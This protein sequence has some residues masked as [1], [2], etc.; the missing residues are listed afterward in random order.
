MKLPTSDFS[1]DEQ[2]NYTKLWWNSKVYFTININIQCSK[3]I[4]NIMFNQ[5]L[6]TGLSM[7]SSYII[8]KYLGFIH[9]YYSKIKGKLKR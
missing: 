7:I 1:K 6:L 5:S 3:E 8:C 9:K 2:F 4:K